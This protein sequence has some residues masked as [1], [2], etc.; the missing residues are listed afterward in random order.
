MSL[1]RIRTVPTASGATAVQVIWRYVNRKPVLD[2]IGSAH[3]DEELALL[4]TKA[5]RLIDGNQL[6][7]NFDDGIQHVPQ[8]EAMTT[9]TKE[10]PLAV[11]GESA[12]YLLD[13]I[14]GA[15]TY[16]GLDNAT[17]DDQVFYNL[18][19]ARLIQPGSKLDSIETLAE[20]GVTSAS[21]STIKRH[22]PTYA[23]PEF[24]NSI[25]PCSCL[26]CGYRSGSIGSL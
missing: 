6:H 9:G 1:P 12:G 3:T 2:H 25:T 17:D 26:S 8:S 21:Y 24:Q 4:M 5:Q 22:L 7:L 16:L 18:V 19:L 14:R 23:T 11:I 13:A 20:V 15:Y 10:D